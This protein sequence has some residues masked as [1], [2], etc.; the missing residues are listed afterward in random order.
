MPD[1]ASQPENMLYPAII[2]LPATGRNIERLRRA[3]GYSVRDLQRLLGLSS[4]QAIYKW[5]R[6]QALPSLDNMVVLSRLFKARIE[7]ILVCK[8]CGRKGE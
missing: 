4:T 2:D 3:A 7:E 5:Q 8:E 1:I 6:G